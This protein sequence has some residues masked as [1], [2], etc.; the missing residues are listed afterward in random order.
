MAIG[1]TVRAAKTGPG[2]RI[3]LRVRSVRVAM[4]AGS[5][6]GATP[7][8]A[9]M[10]APAVMIARGGRTDPGRTSV[11]DAPIVPAATT[12]PVGMCGP[13]AMTGVR[14][15]RARKLVPIVRSSRASR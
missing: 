11:Q 1:R 14:T 2:R 8:L 5:A 12:V 10:G 13:C 6:R 9:V 15:V 7:L 4:T 3:V